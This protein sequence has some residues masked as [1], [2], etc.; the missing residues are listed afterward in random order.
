MENKLK[1]IWIEQRLNKQCLQLNVAKMRVQW[2]GTVLVA[3]LCTRYRVGR[4]ECNIVELK[5]QKKAQSEN[6]AFEQENSANLHIK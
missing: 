3:V 1:A 5:V 4:A 2:L 6:K